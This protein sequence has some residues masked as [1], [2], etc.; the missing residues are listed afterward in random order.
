[1]KKMAF[2]LIFLILVIWVST[3]WGGSVIIQLPFSMT[4]NLAPSTYTFKFSLYDR[5]TDGSLVWVEE[6]V[7]KVTSKTLK[8]NLGTKTPLDVV[9]FS[10]QLWVQV[11]RKIAEN[12]YQVIGTRD[13][14]KVAPYA[15]WSETCGSCGIQVHDANQQYLGILLGT[16]SSG[17]TIYI[18]TLKRMIEITPQD[19]SVVPVINVYFKSTNCTGQPYGQ[20]LFDAPYRIYR[21]AGSND[22]FYTSTTSAGIRRM[23]YS[24][25]LTS[26]NCQSTSSDG[27]WIPL[28]EVTLPFTHPVA[29]PLIFER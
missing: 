25:L 20:G 24:L 2:C 21:L 3:A 7:I 1:M 27:T 11:E 18:P 22:K 9:D 16:S 26:L 6:K 5:L 10:Q 28:E 14:L 13:R 8:T 4:M 12:T 19:S 23:M 29:L 17:I 15:M